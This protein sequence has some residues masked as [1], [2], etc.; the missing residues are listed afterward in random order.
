MLKL[1]PAEPQWFDLDLPQGRVRVQL[2]PITRAA[3]RRA[4]ELVGKAMLAS[5]TPDLAEIGEDM[6][7]ELLRGAIVAWEG[8][9][10]ADGNPVPVTPE[11]IELLL[12]HPDAFAVLNTAYCL[13]WY[14]RDRE[15]NASS[16]SPSGTGMAAMPGNDI[17]SSPVPP[18]ATAAAPPART[19]KT[20]RKLKPANPSGM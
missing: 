18:I 4:R 13:P 17:V 9:G 7:A 20:P 16:G 2:R 10:D 5:E 15:K 14:E 1:A 19:G 3:V 12:Q 6:S 11:N 8:I